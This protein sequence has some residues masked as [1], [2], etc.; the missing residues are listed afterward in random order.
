MN[1]NQLIISRRGAEDAKAEIEPLRHDEHDVEEI[2][3]A[4][5]LVTNDSSHR[6][7]HV[8]PA[9]HNCP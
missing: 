8:I 2:I 9:C 4:L 7:E 1:S 6:E 5:A 3:I